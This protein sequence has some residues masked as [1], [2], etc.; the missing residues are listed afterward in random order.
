MSTILHVK[1]MVCDRC[2]TIVSQSLT[3]IVMSITNLELGAVTIA[4]NDV[5]D[6]DKVQATLESNGFELI[7]DKNEMFIDKIKTSLIDYVNL[8]D[9]SKEENMSDFLSHKL[10]RDYSAMSKLFS[11]T[12]NVSIEKYVI[13][14]KI[15]KAKEL[16]QMNSLSFSEIAYTLAYK[17]SSHLARQFK[18]ITG[19]SMS[20]Y[21]SA[22][23]WD[24]I[25]LDR[26]V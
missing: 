22:Q 20:E 6:F 23:K 26:I 9:S 19:F 18:S 8:I 2:K 21:K 10:N 7:L 11:K 15:E 16:I 13:N 14:L 25:S 3:S 12:E 24:R 5:I 4:T 17:S 1:N